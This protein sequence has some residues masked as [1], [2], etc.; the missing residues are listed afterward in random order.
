MNFFVGN[1][2]P[3][4]ANTIMLASSRPSIAVTKCRR[5][6]SESCGKKADAV[7]LTFSYN[8]DPQNPEHQA[9]FTHE[10]I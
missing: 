8:A 1:V 5:F 6:L 3:E 10:A 7:R 9:K 4:L 2:L